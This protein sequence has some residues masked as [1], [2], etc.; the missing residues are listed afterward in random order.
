MNLPIYK[1][2]VLGEGKNILNI[3]KS[4]KN[5]YVFEICKK[6]I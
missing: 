5:F 2:V 4:W 3:R 1:I 6:L